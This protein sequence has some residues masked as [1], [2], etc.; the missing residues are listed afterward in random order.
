MTLKTKGKAK[1]GGGAM[2]FD[3]TLSHAR[4]ETAHCL[5]PGLFRSLSHGDREQEKLKVSY[6]H[7]E[8][9]NI[10]FS[11]PE[12]LGVDDL[13]V[14]QGLVAMAG[15]HGIILSPEPTADA[16]RQLRLLLDL[17]H[18]DLADPAG[19]RSAVLSRAGRVRGARLAGA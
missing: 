19:A 18:P 3:L 1:G 7:G 15:P 16:P 13:R 12:P 10:E 5:A 6:K 14:L 9:E 2:A 11:G 17:P 8:R 4:L